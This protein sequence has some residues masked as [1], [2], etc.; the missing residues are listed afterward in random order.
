LGFLWRLIYI[1]LCVGSA[2]NIL[3][4]LLL[5]MAE[6]RKNQHSIALKFVVES[7]YVS[8]TTSHYRIRENFAGREIMDGNENYSDKLVLQSF[9][10]LLSLSL[11]LLSSLNHLWL[12]FS[13]KIL[14]RYGLLERE[15][16]FWQNRYLAFQ[17]YHI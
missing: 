17:I 8:P 14:N 3:L 5:T 9:V 12:D 2:P 15:H 10:I 13:H 11:S 6:S 16:Y 4:W 7:D 1:L